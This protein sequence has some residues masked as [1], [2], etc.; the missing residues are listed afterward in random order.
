VEGRVEEFLTRGMDT[1]NQ[2]VGIVDVG[3]MVV[4]RDFL[5][6][7]DKNHFTA[8]PLVETEVQGLTR[9]SFEKMTKEL[10]ALAM[11]VMRG[12]AHSQT[13]RNMALMHELQHMRLQVELHNSGT[14]ALTDHDDSEE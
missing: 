2:R 12:I 5:E 14:T 1:G 8:I 6:A 13:T 3:S 9:Q 10:P 7:E 4:D 11:L